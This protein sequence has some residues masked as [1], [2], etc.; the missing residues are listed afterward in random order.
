MQDE[1]LGRVDEKSFNSA[2]LYHKIEDYK[3]AVM[4][5]KTA[6]KDNPETRH[7][8]EILYLVLS[9]SYQIAKHSVPEKQRD[10]YQ[11][12]IDEYYNIISEFPET[13]HK[14]EADDMHEKALEFLGKK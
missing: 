7:R 9:S 10:R 4:A 12:V 14:K 8:E 1:L 5:L 3:A 13:K 6:L 2:A 11:T